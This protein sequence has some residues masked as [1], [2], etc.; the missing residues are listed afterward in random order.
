MELETVA[1]FMMD[2]S[3]RLREL[4]VDNILRYGALRALAE[5]IDATGDKVAQ[6]GEEELAEG[7]AR[8]DLA[9]AAAANS[10]AM[11][12]AGEEMIAE[13]LATLAAAQGALD[14]GTELE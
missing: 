10:A 13:G 7:E 6:L 3:Q 1:G 9:E 5:N 4:A 12:V 11:A 8:L 2:R 14:A